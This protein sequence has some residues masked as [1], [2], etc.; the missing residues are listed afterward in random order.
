LFAG[1]LGLMRLLPFRDWLEPL[2]MPLQE[3]GT[4]G[5]L[6][7]ALVGTLLALCFVPVSVPVSLSGFLF[8]VRS[9]FWVSSVILLGGTSLGTLAGTFL[10]PRL[11]DKPV[12][13]HQLFQAVRRVMKR[14]GLWT[15]FLLRMSPFFHFM[16][17]NLFLGSLHL[18]FFRYLGISYLGMIPGTLLVVSAGHIASQT[19]LGSPDLPVWQ[20][21]LFSIGVLV[22]ASVSWHITARTRE[23]LGNDT[24]QSSEEFPSGI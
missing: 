7:F 2:L 18:P 20:G 15:V 10:W 12:F 23:E 17:G 14:N 21:G 5:K 11:K 1:F 6:L 8:G 13:Q 22:F 3:L 9:G 16:T 4:W 19:L 24:P